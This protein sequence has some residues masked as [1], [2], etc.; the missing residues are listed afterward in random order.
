M[1]AAQK[2][3]RILDH[4][5]WNQQELADRLGV[6]QPTVNRWLNRRIRWLSADHRDRIDNLYREVFGP[7]ELSLSD[8]YF[9][10]S[11]LTQRMLLLEPQKQETIFSIIALAIT[12]AERHD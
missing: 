2:L 4:T 6:S 12:L 1:D 9:W 11:S 3:R 8:A 10:P 7:A 5:H